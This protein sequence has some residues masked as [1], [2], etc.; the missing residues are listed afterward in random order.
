MR[1]GRRLSLGRWDHQ[2]VAVGLALAAAVFIAGCGSSPHDAGVT[3]ADHRSLPATGFARTPSAVLRACRA[4]VSRRRVR[5]RCPARLPDSGWAVTERTLVNDRCAYLLNLAGAPVDSTAPA[6]HL[7]LGGRCGQFSLSERA[8]RWQPRPHSSTGQD[9][10]L[11]P[12]RAPSDDAACRPPRMLAHATVDGHRALLLEVAPFPAGGVHGGHLVAL[13]NQGAAGYLV[14]MH[15][16]GN[17]RFHSPAM[18]KVVLATA[19]SVA[20]SR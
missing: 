11:L 14:S 5:V 19:R 6:F 10:G 9:L 7:L 2:T 15:F 20:D 18:N 1:S 12:C 8:G 17:D 4:L 3:V 13:W 16:A